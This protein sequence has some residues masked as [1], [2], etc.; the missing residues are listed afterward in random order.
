MP[1][2]PIAVRV[3]DL[4]AHTGTDYPP[5]HDA[6]CRQ[7]RR[8]ALGNEFGLS[9][10]GVNILELPPGTWSSQRHWHE[11]QDE[12]V[13]VLE[14]EVV[15]VTDEGETILTQGMTAGFR[16]GVSNGHH[17]VNR[18]IALTRVIEVGTRTT[19][20]VAHYPDIGMMVR[21]N[22]DGSNY[23]ATDGRPMK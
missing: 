9:Q 19:E 8:T 5:P 11:R 6:P 3:V 20:E 17:L 18:S 13:Y 7:R 15:L 1:E 16:A 21:D 23:F 2:R 10:F 12:L 14:G 22:A 4:P